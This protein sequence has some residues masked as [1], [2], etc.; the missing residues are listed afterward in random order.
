M[1]TDNSHTKS[2]LRSHLRALRQAHVETL[3]SS[4]K[5]LLFR[6]PP[7]PLLDLVPSGSAIG[8]YHANQWE[9][10][11]Q[12]YASHLAEKGHSI[13][14]PRFADSAAAMEF[15][16]WTDFYGETDLEDGAFGIKQPS[17]YAPK[18]SPDVLFVPLVGFSENGERLGQGGGHY[19]RWLAD[20]PDAIA[21]GLAWDCQLSH[22]IP[23]EE[24]DRP[25]RAIITPTRFYGP[26]HA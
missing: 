19:D 13:A 7:A 5:G 21:I 1:T 23:M 2:E 4:T 8:V 25:L 17:S 14:L 18:I 24:H 9:A 20:N 3:P 10:P 12:H 26:F 11:A 16:Q 15:A 22:A 6:V